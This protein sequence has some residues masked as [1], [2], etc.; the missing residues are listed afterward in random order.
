MRAPRPARDQRRLLA[1]AAVLALAIG[2]AACGIPASGAPQTISRSDAPYQLLVPPS[3]TTTTLPQVGAQVTIYMVNNVTDHLQ[4]VTREVPPQTKLTGL[5][6]ALLDGPTSRETAENLVSF[7][8]ASP[9]DVQA[10][11]A[12]NGVA[13]LDFAVN[14]VE[15]IGP[16]Q[17]LAIA[18]VVFTATEQPGVT[19]VLFEI[20]GE[21]INVPAG[22]G[23]LVGNPVNRSSYGPQA[24]LTSS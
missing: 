21:P 10:S 1:L 23:Q 14:P 12:S 16:S 2:L 5:L 8:S 3:T 24:P 11:V 15:V 6:G 22:D 17:A 20:S 19:G 18:Q 9:G 7:L 13:T 4:P